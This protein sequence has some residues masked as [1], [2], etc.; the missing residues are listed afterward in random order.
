[1]SQKQYLKNVEKEIGRINRLIDQKIMRGE[2][3][4]KEA[5]DHKLLLRKIRFC[6]RQNFLHSLSQKFSPKFAIF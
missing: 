4:S 1:M 6:R 3:Y 2:E 5:H